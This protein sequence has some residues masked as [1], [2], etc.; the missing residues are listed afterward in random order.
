MKI[1]ACPVRCDVGLERLDAPCARASGFHRQVAVKREALAVHAGG[2]QREQDR[3]RSDQRHHGDPR[4]GAPPRRA[5]RPDRRSPGQPASD[6]S[7]TSM[8]V[9]R[10]REKLGAARRVGGSSPSST[11]A[12]SRIGR[13]GSSDCRKARA[14]F[15]FSTTIVGEAAGDVDRVRRQH[16]LGRNHA[17]QVRHEIE[18]AR[19]NDLRRRRV[20]RAARARRRRPRA[21]ST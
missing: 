15:A 16:V 1:C 6:R 14:G 12:I 10:G 5:A 4:R 7:P 17:E 8:T 11:M 2:H 20:N 19:H 13:T 18:R 3:R 9:A 21:A